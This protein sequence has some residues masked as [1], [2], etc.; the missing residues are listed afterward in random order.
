ML[1][2]DYY[3][4]MLETLNLAKSNPHVNWIFKQHPSIK[5]YSV[6]DVAYPE[7]FSQLPPHI[8]YISEDNQIDTRSV[9][10]CADL[11]VTCLGSAGFELPALA[12]IP[13]IIA[14]VNHYS[15][16][17]IASEPQTVQEYS[18]YLL[19][20]RGSA[21]LSSEIIKRARATYIF[22]YKY[23]RVPVHVCP[24]A[25]LEEEKSPKQSDWYWAKVKK[26]HLKHK[27]DIDRESKLYT[28]LIGRKSFKRLTQI[29]L[30]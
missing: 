14:G 26:Q 7:L 18:N 27:E 21:R 11:V 2:L 3:H 24:Q 22:I 29:E 12:G 10:N 16:L 15:G 8:K 4:W 28:K 13:S 23:S 30:S 20:F 6:K 1:F 19:N 9:A 5:Y 17:G 25:T